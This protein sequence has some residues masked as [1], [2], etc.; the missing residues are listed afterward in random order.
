[1]NEIAIFGTLDAL[2][3]GLREE[4]RQYGEILACFDDLERTEARGASHEELAQ[5]VLDQNPYP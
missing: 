2:A 1:M 4:P 3:R 5:R